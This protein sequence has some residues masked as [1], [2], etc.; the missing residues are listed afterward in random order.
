MNNYYLYA[1]LNAHQ[2]FTHFVT[3]VDGLLGV[4]AEAKLKRLAS[5]LTTKWREPYL[6]TCRYLKCR[7]AVHHC[8]HRY[9]FPVS[10]IIV[11]CPQ[12]EERVVLH[13]FW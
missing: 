4:K 8:I 12:W 3:S 2:N 1:C 10:Q 11:T 6:R 5:R 9:R 7:A 13:L